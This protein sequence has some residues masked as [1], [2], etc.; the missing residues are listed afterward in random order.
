M[1]ESSVTKQE[2]YREKT[3]I[4]K[5]DD[6]VEALD[7]KTKILSKLITENIKKIKKSK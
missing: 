3:P 1:S 5:W 2:G 4:E 7:M 6:A